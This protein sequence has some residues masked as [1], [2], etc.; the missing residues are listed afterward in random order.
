MLRGQTDRMCEGRD[1]ETKMKTL[2]ST[3]RETTY[4][5][6]CR[7]LDWG[8]P[9]ICQLCWEPPL[10]TVSPARRIPCTQSDNLTATT[11][12]RCEVHTAGDKANQTRSKLFFFFFFFWWKFCQTGRASFAN[13]GCGLCLPRKPPQLFRPR[14]WRVCLPLP[15]G[16]V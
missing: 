1:E 12:H 2:R 6:E 10:A 5:T 15:P 16:F 8:G 13:K 7:G 3:T 14:S 4:C 11:K 9:C